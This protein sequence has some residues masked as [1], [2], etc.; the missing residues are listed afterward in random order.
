LRPAEIRQDRFAHLNLLLFRDAAT[1]DWTVRR[2]QREVPHHLPGFQYGWVA[3][4][5]DASKYLFRGEPAELDGGFSALRADGSALLL[6]YPSLPWVVHEPEVLSRPREGEDAGLQ[7]RRSYDHDLEALSTS[8]LI[9]AQEQCQRGG[10]HEGHAAEIEDHPS[11][12]L[13]SKDGEGGLHAPHVGA[14]EVASNAE[15]DE[16]VFLMGPEA[17]RVRFARDTCSL[18]PSRARTRRGLSGN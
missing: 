14:V 12:G 15:V 3:A 18:A 4:A 8:A 2:D 16:S 13:T 17:E 9:G 7:G 10:V 5:A 6:G 1:A 11:E